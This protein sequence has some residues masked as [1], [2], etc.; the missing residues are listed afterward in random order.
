MLG[1]VFG[2]SITVAPCWADQVPAAAQEEL[3]IQPS[4]TGV[5]HQVSAA[6]VDGL[7][8]GH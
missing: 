2:I 3:A 4:Q 8:C 7:E 6:A 1:L 5:P